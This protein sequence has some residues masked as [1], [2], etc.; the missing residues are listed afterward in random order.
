MYV[1][2]T[3]Y[4]ADIFLDVQ[5]LYYGIIDLIAD[6]SWTNA[7]WVTV[8]LV[9]T[10]IPFIPALSSMRHL[11]KV[12]DV[13]DTFKGFRLS[14]DTFDTYKALKKAGSIP[15]TEVHHLIEKRFLPSGLL[16]DIK[17]GDILSVRLDKVAHQG[18]TNEFR[19]IIPYGYNYYQLTKPLLEKAI[20]GAYR[21]YPE[22]KRIALGML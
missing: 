21:N 9:F 5:F 18:I 14:D 11:G 3:G 2:H 20:N 13:V 6:P 16:G 4:W 8:D 15:G 12:D 1:D 22:F 17:H 10:I 7:G 19:R